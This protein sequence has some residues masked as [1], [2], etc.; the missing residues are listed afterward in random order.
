MKDKLHRGCLST[1][2]SSTSTYE[3]KEN[4]IYIIQLER[5]Y[6]FIKWCPNVAFLYP[7]KTSEIQR[8][9]DVFRGK[10]NGASDPSGL[11]VTDC[12][13][14]GSYIENTAKDMN[15]RIAITWKAI[16]KMSQIWKSEIPKSSKI[17]V[18]I[19]KHSAL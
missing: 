6:S 15:I 8:L 12:K 13:Y 18:L 16:N 7:P 17:S 9:S 14:F 3:R 19:G 2:F 4:W 5:Y 11:K 1:N 10:R